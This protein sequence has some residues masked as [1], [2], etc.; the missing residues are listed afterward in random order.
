MLTLMVAKWVGDVFNEGLYDM[1]I[2][3]KRIPF[4]HW[5]VVSYF[6]FF[7]PFLCFWSFFIY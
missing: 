3:L 5:F 4:L 2:E 1:H 6:G 7:F